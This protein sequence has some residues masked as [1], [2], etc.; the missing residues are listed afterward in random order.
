MIDINIVV[1]FLLKNFVVGHPM[2]IQPHIRFELQTLLYKRFALIRYNPL[3]S[4][5]EVHAISFKHY[6]FFQY[7]HLTHGISKGLL[8]IQHLEV[9]NSY[10]PNIN[11][12]SDESL[13]LRKALWR[14]IP[15]SA[16]PLRGELDGVL[17]GYFTK[18]E[19]S[20]FDHPFME[21]YVLWFQ[22]VVDDF[23]GQIVQVANCTNYLSD[24]EFGLLF[25]YLFVL[26]EVEREVGSLAVLQHSAERVRVNFYSV[27]KPDDVGMTQHFMHG[28][29]SDRM[30]NVVVLGLRIPLGIKLVDFD[31]HLA[32]LLSVVAFVDLAE[33][34]AA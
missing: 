33:A 5:W 11:F 23:I 18:S 30:L 21:E 8:A 12:G 6:P 15:I 16:D 4:V 14:E 26:L 13:L 2:N 32:Q 10:A 34:T 29:L 9:N 24:D 19:I 27:I 3:L 25:G 7:P 1:S 17:L 28:V 22:V 31:C 20:D